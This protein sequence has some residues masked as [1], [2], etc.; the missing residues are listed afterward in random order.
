[1]SN[2]RPLRQDTVLDL[3]DKCLT[4]KLIMLLALTPACQV[5]GL[6]HLD[7]GFMTKGTNNYI[8][9]FEKLHKTWTP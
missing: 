9:T 4:C 1:M 6:Q 7:I 5:L 8:L 2:S 3:S